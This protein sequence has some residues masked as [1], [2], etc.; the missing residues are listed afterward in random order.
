MDMH[1]RIVITQSHDS[2]LT[3]PASLSSSL[4]PLLQGLI[5][6]ARE[7]WSARSDKGCWLGKRGNSSTT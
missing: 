3:L 6:K 7:D 4:T 1:R 2:P 5:N